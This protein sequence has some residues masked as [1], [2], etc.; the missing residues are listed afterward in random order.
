MDVKYLDMVKI[1]ADLRLEL[2][3]AVVVE[4]NI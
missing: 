2:G 3:V 1:A 4:E